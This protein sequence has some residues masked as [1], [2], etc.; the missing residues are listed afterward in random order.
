VVAIEAVTVAV[1]TA[2]ATMFGTG[3]YLV[4]QRG[5]V[6]VVWGVLLM[7]QGANVYL[8]AMGGVGGRAPIVDGGGGYTDPLVQAFV[9]TAIVI[10]FGVGAFALALTVRVYREHGSI[11]LAELAGGRSTDEDSADA[12]DGEPITDGGVEP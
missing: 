1:A 3:T 5:L 12:D 8:V 6:R 11:D 4:F 7:S 10:G 2:V 9:L